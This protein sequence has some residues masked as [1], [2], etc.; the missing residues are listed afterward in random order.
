M[1]TACLYPTGNS[2]LRAVWPLSPL[3]GQ[4][5]ST[6]HHPVG[7]WGRSLVVG[8]EQHSDY[9]VPTFNWVSGRQ[10]GE[11]PRW[12]VGCPTLPGAPRTPS[13]GTIPEPRATSTTWWMISEWMRRSHIAGHHSVPCMGDL[14]LWTVNPKRGNTIALSFVCPVSTMG[15]ARELNQQGG[16]WVNEV[17][18]E[19][20]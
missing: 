17:M 2:L 16:D 6:C 18:S 1:A 9:R 5:P 15:P 11:T 20:P 12:W 14:C 8:A 13:E 3:Q 10:A 4:A 7:A 19:R